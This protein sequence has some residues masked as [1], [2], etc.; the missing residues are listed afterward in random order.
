MT[1]PEGMSW[2][3]LRSRHLFVRSRYRELWDHISAEFC[4]WKDTNV[5]NA[6]QRVLLLGNTGIGKTAAI[7]YFLRR[8][9]EAEYRVLVE[10]RE[11]RYYFHDRT[12]EW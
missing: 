8:A 1:L 12:V 7:N 11:R 4:I 5:P 2:L 10:T 3:T 9:L 6:N